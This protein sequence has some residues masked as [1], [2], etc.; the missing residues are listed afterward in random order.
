MSIVFG[1]SSP[2]TLQESSLPQSVTWCGREWP[3]C[4][5]RAWVPGLTAFCPSGSSEQSAWLSLHDETRLG[6][7]LLSVRVIYLGRYGPTAAES[8]VKKICLRMNP[9]KGKKMGK[10]ET[11]SFYAIIWACGSSIISQESP[12]FCLSWF[13]LD[14]D[15]SQP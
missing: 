3:I 13:G 11:Q 7:C 8:F 5:G 10:M 6:F 15:Y 1:N 9:H 14:F 2:L 4:R 12:S